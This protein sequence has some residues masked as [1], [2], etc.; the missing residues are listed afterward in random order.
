MAYLA[1]KGVSRDFHGIKPAE[2][3]SGHFGLLSG[4]HIEAFTA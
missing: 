1:I 2:P 3:D 4:G